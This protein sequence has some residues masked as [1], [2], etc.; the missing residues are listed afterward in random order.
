MWKFGLRYIIQTY[1]NDKIKF[2]GQSVWDISG[3][4]R[5]VRAAQCMHQTTPNM[6]STGSTELPRFQ[7][8]RKLANCVHSTTFNSHSCGLRMCLQAKGYNHDVPSTLQQGIS[9]L[10]NHKKDTHLIKGGYSCRVMNVRVWKYD[11]G[12]LSHLVGFDPTHS[13]GL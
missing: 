4:L 10:S 13:N 1:S 9:A 7:V 5:H 11:L 3:L 6:W 2:Q 8:A 12:N